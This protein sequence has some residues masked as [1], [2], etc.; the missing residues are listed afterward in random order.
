M[1]PSQDR[2]HHCTATPPPDRAYPNV[3][4]AVADPGF[5]QGGVNPGIGGHQDKIKFSP[6]KLHEIEKNLAARGGRMSG[7]PP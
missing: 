2:A 1:T 3:Q 7:P 5:S 4:V 6:R